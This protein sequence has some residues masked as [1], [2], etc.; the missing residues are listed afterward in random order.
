MN[1]KLLKEM[2]EAA[3]RL[4]IVYRKVQVRM[5]GADAKKVYPNMKDSNGGE[6]QP[7]KFYIVPMQQ[8]VN[9]YK[10]MKAIFKQRGVKAVDEYILAHAANATAAVL[11]HE[12]VQKAYNERAASFSI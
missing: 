4:P 1:K 12:S 8:S 10:E 3:V 6:L 11:G 2:R 5:S 9:H 7:E